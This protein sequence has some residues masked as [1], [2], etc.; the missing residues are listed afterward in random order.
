MK[1]QG[2]FTVEIHKK[3]TVVKRVINDDGF[4]VGRSVDCMIQLN[5]SSISRVHVEVT[6]RREQV[7]IE[8]K[9]SSNGTFINGTKITAN[10]PI[11]VIASDKIQIGK[12]EYI[13]CIDLSLEEEEEVPVV[14]QIHATPHAATA[15]MHAEQVPKNAAANIPPVVAV[16]EEDRSRTHELRP[17]SLRAPMPDYSSPEA[18]NILHEARK[19]AA[20]L[21][22]EGEIQAEK[23]VQAI[24]KRAQEL[25]SEAETVSKKK[26]ADAHKEADALLN[27]Y[28]SQG[29]DLLKDARKFSQEMRDE[30]HAYVEMVKAKADQE[31]QAILSESRRTSEQLRAE[32]VAEARSQ[33]EQES[34]ALIKKSKIEADEIVSKARLDADDFF[35]EIESHK[36]EVAALQKSLAQAQVDSREAETSAAVFR[37]Q[38]KQAREDLLNV[39]TSVA[40]NTKELGMITEE[41]KVKQKKVEELKGLIAARTMELR[42]VEESKKQ[43]DHEVEAKRMQLKE[44]FEREERQFAKNSE[45][46]IQDANAELKKRIE[47][48]EMDLLTELMHKRELLQKE[49]FNQVEKVC[50]P[51]MDSSEWS[52]M[53]KDVQ[54]AIHNSFET[55]LVDISQSSVPEVGKQTDLQKKRRHDNN[56][57]LVMGVAMGALLFFIGET[58]Y[59][60]V[61]M[62]QNPLKTRTLAEA[63]KRQEDLQRRKFAPPQVDEIKD[64]YTDSVIYTK[65]FSQKYL[66]A[67]FQKKFYKAA[68]AYLLKTWRLEEEKSI[69]VLAASAAIVKELQEKRDLIHPDYVKE[70]ILKMR[71]L[72]NATTQRMKDILGSEVRLDSYRKFEKNFYTQ[73]NP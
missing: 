42:S 25:Q 1:P 62:D 60:I 24:Y 44:R 3:E 72:E 23:K 70:G 37:S 65:N 29:Q 18:D 41:I 58:A 27:R 45:D 15:H 52:S 12:S 21:I 48:M 2:V 8:D 38:E 36:D 7:W 63:Q 55:K 14:P 53:T 30:V 6:R 73:E 59:K 43:T 20:Q 61:V 66:D 67:E 4:A 16:E 33:V 49:V 50:R 19:K 32:L 39:Q 13:L 64:N 35:K 11:N 46:R 26:L 5:D 10:V 68:S 47:K 69:E 54:Q 28:E 56:R 34:E 9:G 17:E 51:H 40:D 22:Y 31:A 71:T 57:S